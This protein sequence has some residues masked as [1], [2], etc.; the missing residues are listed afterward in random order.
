MGFAAGPMTHPE[1]E[2][3][4][5]GAK[6]TAPTFEALTILVI[7]HRTPQL[8][9]EC[10]TRL[11]RYAV[12]ARV[13]VVDS[14]PPSERP[15]LR[16]RLLGAELLGVPNHS[17]AHAVNC[18]LRL[19]RTPFVAHMNADVWVTPETFPALLAALEPTEVAMTGPV[20]RTADG[21]RQHQGPTYTLLYRR[22]A[23][24]RGEPASLPVPW[25]SG[26]LQVL[27]WRAVAHVGGM[28]ASLRFYNEDMEWCFRLWRAGW[29]C[30][31]VA[32]EV[33]HL[34]GA[35]TP[36]DP[37]FLIEGYRGGYRLSQRFRGPLYRA[38]HR[39]AVLAQSALL[40]RWGREAHT[41]AAFDAIFEMFRHQQFDRSP[42]G[43]T[44]GS[45][46]DA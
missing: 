1:L 26:C 32:T 8:L 40:R 5:R 35:S 10:L 23:A 12:G 4:R 17:L 28:D 22:L 37:R 19:V 9:G 13:I 43:A 41:R 18:G 21:R 31:L 7:H 29:T 16:E 36:R 30:R 46:T 33:V 42:F 39:S 45:D 44:L 38:L 3:D 25:L 24:Q 2:V 6:L 11:A 15:A 27:K 14:G 34:G 20:A